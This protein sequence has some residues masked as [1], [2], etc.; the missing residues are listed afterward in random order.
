MAKKS[1][2]VEAVKAIGN[3]EAFRYFCERREIAK[4]AGNAPVEAAQIAHDETMGK[5][6]GTEAAAGDDA[7]K[8]AFNI[9][10]YDRDEFEVTNPLPLSQI[11]P[12][13]AT[14]MLVEGLKPSDAPNSDAWAQLM[15]CRESPANRAEFYKNI[16][17]KLLPNKTQLEQEARFHDDGS[18]D[19][20]HIARV[21][22]AREAAV[23][24]TGP[25]RLRSKHGFSGGVDSGR[26]EE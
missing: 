19:L 6:G 10:L 14:S 22:A 20:E 15:W 25:K 23:L 26:V 7:P 17:P 8:P 4:R 18:E 9:T 2:L 12:W 11:I 5:F 21:R 1:E 24:S 13:I 16:Y 3:P